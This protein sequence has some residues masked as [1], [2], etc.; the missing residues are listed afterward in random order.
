[1][2]LLWRSNA[3]ESLL[4]YVEQL[5]AIGI[6]IEIINLGGGYPCAYAS[7]Q[8]DISLKEIACHAHAA[9]AKLPVQPALVLEPGRGIIA[10]AA[11]MV[12]SVIARVERRGRTWLF[13]DAGVYNALYEALAFQGSTRYKVEALRRSR[14]RREATF[15]LAGPTG[16]GPDIIMR[17]MLLPEDV[18]VGDKLIFYSVG[19]YSLAVASSFNGF[20]K[21]PVY[22]T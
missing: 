6:E 15:S 22:F 17:D 21:P 14:R 11:I 10:D 7:S 1:M 8:E 2:A 19:A 3:V 13:L 9:L 18:A 5:C 4:P 12:S 16:D 20:P